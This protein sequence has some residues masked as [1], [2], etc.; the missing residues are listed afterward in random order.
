MADFGEKKIQNVMAANIIEN[1]KFFEIFLLFKGGQKKISR[2]F[3]GRENFF[4]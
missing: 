4:K 1:L 3:R 2:F